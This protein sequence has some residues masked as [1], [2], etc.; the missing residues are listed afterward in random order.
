MYAL[1]G[2]WSKAIEPTR[3]YNN[4]SFDLAKRKW[5][6]NRT[7]KS[8]YNHEKSPG[9]PREHIIVYSGLDIQD[10][11]GE[12]GRKQIQLRDEEQERTW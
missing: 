8:E 1:D 12:E 5:R 10:K 7:H 11:Y 2:G 9:E 3:N 6:E 4:D